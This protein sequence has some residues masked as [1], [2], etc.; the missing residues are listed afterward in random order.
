MSKKEIV[1]VL[2]IDSTLVYTDNSRRLSDLILHDKK[3][4][5]KKD[6]NFLRENIYQLSFK[7]GTKMSGLY[8]KDLK[9]FMVKAHEFFDHVGI[10]SAGQDEYVDEIVKH[11][12][13]RCRINKSNCKFIKP[14]SYCERNIDDN[15]YK[16]L[17]KLCSENNYDQSKMV[18]IDDTKETFYKNKDNAIH[19]PPL[20]L[21][22][23][24]T[25]SKIYNKYIED[26][27]LK[28]LIPVLK[29]LSDYLRNGGKVEDFIREQGYSEI[30]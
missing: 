10:W 29:N 3:Y 19:I 1:L 16:P 2:D 25:P 15:Y 21:N 11:I 12:Y 5:Q 6:V 7:D 8:R 17:S 27:T 26:N 22:Y 23:N 24:T 30:F 14:R 18:I 20:R 4:S 28:K 13:N 9:E